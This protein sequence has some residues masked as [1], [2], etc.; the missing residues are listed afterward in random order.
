MP[1]LVTVRSSPRRS[2]TVS[3]PTPP[4]EITVNRVTLTAHLDDLQDVDI[5]GLPQPYPEDVDFPYDEDMRYTLVYNPTVRQWI[6]TPEPV[7]TGIDGGT[8]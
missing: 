3:T 7:V 1:I 2:V 5:S 8:Y 6:A 4:P